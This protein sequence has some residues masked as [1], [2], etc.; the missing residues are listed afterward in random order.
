MLY[1][2]EINEKSYEKSY[3]KT[4]EKI[5]EKLFEKSYEKIYE[6]I[7]NELNKSKKP[8][9]PIQY[10]LPMSQTNRTTKDLSHENRDKTMPDYYAQ[11]IKEQKWTAL[12]KQKKE[13]KR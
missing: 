13:Q 4:S 6:Q 2:F 1:R 5:A 7:N 10:I 11:V 8:Y 12:K 3:E 9:L